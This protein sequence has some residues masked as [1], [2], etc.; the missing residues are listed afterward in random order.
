MGLWGAG[1]AGADAKPKYLTDAEKLNCT[2]TMAGWTVPAGGNGRTAADREVLVAIRGLSGATKL[3]EANISRISLST[4][5]IG[6]GAGGPFTVIATFN[7]SVTVAG[8]SQPQLLVTNNTAAGRN[9]TLVY[10]SGSG[11]NR[12]HF[13]ATVEGGALNESDAIQVQADS[14]SLNGA[15]IVDTVGGANALLTHGANATVITVGA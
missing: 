13:T 12:L 6:A 4:T 7:E 8:E 14:I 9:V 15:T 3:A 11:S 2:G 5:T 10:A 1:A